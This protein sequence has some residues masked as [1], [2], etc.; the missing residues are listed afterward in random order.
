[1]RLVSSLGETCCSPAPFFCSRCDVLLLHCCC[2]H[3]VVPQREHLPSP[4]NMCVHVWQ[5][6]CRVLWCSV[7]LA[8][9][10]V[11]AVFH[12]APPK[13][14]S[15]DLKRGVAVEIPRGGS[16]PRAVI[17]PPR[18][19]GDAPT[20]TSAEGRGSTSRIE[21]A[22]PSVPLLRFL[23][24]FKAGPVG[25]CVRYQ[26]REKRATG[27]SPRKIYF[28][29]TA[30]RDNGKRVSQRMKR[31]EVCTPPARRLAFG[32]DVRLRLCK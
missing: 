12:P 9:V 21:G 5:A 6:W 2:T 3:A 31:C 24:S 20:P 23:L 1:M 18:A 29:K 19:S 10:R 14:T 26:Q 8:C 27:S 30:T 11:A 4:A 25:V 13:A 17:E 15:T 7:C 28:T 32:V 22:Q 16:F